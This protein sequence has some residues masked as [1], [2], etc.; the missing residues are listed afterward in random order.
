MNLLKVKEYVTPA[1]FAYWEEVGSELGFSYTASG[2]L[3]R[4]AHH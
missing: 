3:V 4:D 1:K 2:P